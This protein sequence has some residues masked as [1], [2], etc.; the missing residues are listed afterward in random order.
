[1]K[2]LIQQGLAVLCA[3]AALAGVTIAPEARSESPWPSKPIVLVSPY[4]PGGSTDVLARLISARLNGKLGQPV[5]V[6]NRP[7]AGGN[8]GTAYVAK[9][10]PDGHTFLLASSGP[11]VI[12][13]ALYPKLNYHPDADFTAVSPVARTG[14][15]VTVN[16]KSGLASLKDVIAKGKDGQLAFGSAGSGTPQHIIGEMFNMAAKTKLQHIPYKGSGPLLNDLIGGQ[17]PLAFDNPL[18]VMQQVKVGNLKALA[19]TGSKRSAALPDVPTLAESGLEGFDAQ[20]W[21]GVLG[22]AGLPPVITDRM[23]AEIQA[24]LSSA[25]VRAQLAALD[26]DPMIMK[27]KQFQSFIAADI[28][29]WNAAVKASGATVD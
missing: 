4:A 18:V 2:H 21:Y 28:V 3:I 27:P 23:N 16:A 6:E 19:V 8:L 13:G 20:P 1:M 22:P 24:I 15:V 7:G 9:A 25:E 11:I 12:A 14:Y 10:K 17:V 26:V 29:K 5:V